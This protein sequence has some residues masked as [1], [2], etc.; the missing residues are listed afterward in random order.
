MESFA[1]IRR[2][3][4]MLTGMGRVERRRVEGPW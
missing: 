4:R 1:V 3:T 2:R